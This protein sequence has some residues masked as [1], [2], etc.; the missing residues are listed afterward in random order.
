MIDTVVGN[1]K[2]N[3]EATQTQLCLDIV[4]LSLVEGKER[5]ETEWEKLFLE[6]GFTSYKITPGLGLRSIIEVFP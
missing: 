2:G 5:T 3:S 1:E 6:A 4:I